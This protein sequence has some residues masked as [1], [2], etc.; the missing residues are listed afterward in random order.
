MDNFKVIPNEALHP[1][2]TERLMWVS[3]CLIA[4]RVWLAGGALRTLI[5]PTDEIADYDLFFK[6]PTDATIVMDWLKS[7]GWKLVF[8]CPKKELYTYKR[9]GVKTQ[10]ITKH[11]YPTVYELLDSF[12]FTVCQAAIDSK[13]L[14]FSRNWLSSIRKQKLMI[15]KVTYPV[16]TINRMMKYRAKGYRVDEHMLIDL[17][18]EISNR[19]FEQDQLAMYVD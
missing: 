9:R 3:E 8:E 7:D 12:D 13:N 4:D 10:C 5:R 18:N 1:W 17:V 14:Y 11:Y 15:N 16:A 6:S 2:R 19:Q